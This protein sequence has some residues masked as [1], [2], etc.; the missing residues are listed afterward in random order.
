MKQLKRFTALLLL[1]GV[2]FTCLVACGE[3]GD[4]PTPQHQHVDYA[5]NVTLDMSSTDTVK[6]KVTVI[7][8][9]PKAKLRLWQSI[10]K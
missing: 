5:S 8:S 3:G 4:D 1:L 2:M 6:Q 10:T 9:K 7:I